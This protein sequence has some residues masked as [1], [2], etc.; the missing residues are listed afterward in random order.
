[1]SNR[2]FTTE[3]TKI[4]ENSRF[5][6]QNSRDKKNLNSK[7]FSRVLGKVAILMISLKLFF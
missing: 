5:F 1:M 2:N 3:H 4:V 6:V 7:D